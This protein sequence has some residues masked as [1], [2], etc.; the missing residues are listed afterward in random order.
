MVQ[1]WAGYVAR[2]ERLEVAA[3]AWAERLGS[4]KDL[5]AELVEFVDKMLK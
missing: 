2:R 3:R 1:P 4:R 5:A